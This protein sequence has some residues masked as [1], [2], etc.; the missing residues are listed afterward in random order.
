MVRPGRS[1]Q[2]CPLDGQR[3]VFSRPVCALG[4]VSRA[5]R[6]PT[7]RQILARQPPNCAWT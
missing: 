1:R 5:R 2:I 4:G 6:R 3:R 7:A